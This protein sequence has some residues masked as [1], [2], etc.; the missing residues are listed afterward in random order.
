MRLIIEKCLKHVVEG[1]ERVSGRK[2]FTLV[3]ETTSLEAKQRNSKDRN[4]WS[5]VE[6]DGDE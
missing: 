4:K 5:K 1:P 3:I 6:V 2:I